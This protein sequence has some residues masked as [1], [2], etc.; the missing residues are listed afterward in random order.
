MNPKQFLGQVMV[1]TIVFASLARAQ[2]VD[3]IDL[4]DASYPVV[5]TPT[6]LRQSL[7][8]VPASVTIITADTLRRHGITRIEEALRMVPGMAVSQATG[9]D[10]RINFHGTSATSPRRLNVLIDGVSAYMPA[11]S[12]VPWSLL[13]VALEDV[14]RIEVIRGPDSSAYGPNSM[15]A[16]VNILTKHPK[17]VERGLVAMSA[18]AHS[19]LDGTVRLATNV[20][21]TSLRATVSSRHDHGYDSSTSY[22]AGRDGTSINQ[23]NLRAQH[24]LGGG[25]SLDVQAAYVGG[26]IEDGVVDPFQVSP[27][28]QVINRSVLSGRWTK[29]LSAVHEIQV[30]ASHATTSARQR[31]TSC[32]PQAA[33]WPEVRE[34]FQSNPELVNRVLAGQPPTG[35]SARDNELLGQIVLRLLGQ[36]GLAS[37]L[38]MTTCGSVN[39]DGW[40][41]R[42]QIEVQDTFVMSDQLRFVGGAGLRH[43][44]ASSETYF[45]GSVSNNVQWVF[46]HAEY[47][48]VDWLTTNVGGYG[49]SNSLSGSTFSPR[50][51]VNV[52]LS[53]HQT[54]RA[55]VSKGTRTPDLF[56]ERAN[57]SY[58]VRDLSVPIDG[59]TTGHLFTAVKAR[60]DLSSEQIWSH[61]L[62]YLL[63]LPRIGLSLDARVFDDHLSKL[64][65][66]RL[67]TLDFSPDNSGS[68]RLTG[69]ELQLNWT[70]SD[71]WSTWANYGY[72]LSRE[73]SHIE[74]TMQYSR[75][76]GALGVSL[77]FSKNWSAGVAHYAA[78]GD[79]VYQL[80]YGRTDL[81]IG[82]ALSMGAQAGSL[83]LTLSYLDVP[84]VNTYLDAT[85]Y[86]T[87][88]YDRQLSIHGQ[89]RVAF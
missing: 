56:E 34:L 75:H 70:L 15:T 55:V 29:S 73:V 80:R 18:G 22:G 85:R 74:E 51:A 31:W 39:Q 4:S 49:E 28:D 26:K 33:Y 5:I 84:A 50:L 46:G 63:M 11:F 27:P 60:S 32:W 88:R 76:S 30:N 38:A 82:H 61:E 62:G 67:T 54:V 78:S 16:V 41:S 57:W 14:E 35:G 79:G 42:T 68:V 52:R 45:G 23:L 12:Q 7:A 40:E 48:P 17:D 8:D 83:S 9:N 86:F 43:Q 72:L 44:R 25:S 6:R 47:R 77:A 3:A 59:S 69:A 65:S 13:P 10:F 24:E 89:V 87:S 21:A 66:E 81:T 36:G 37:S 1:A 58:T 64:I 71:R 53:D 20:G 19:M 2:E